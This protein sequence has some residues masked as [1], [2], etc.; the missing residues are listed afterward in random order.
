M[1]RCEDYE[2]NVMALTASLREY[3]RKFTITW[4]Q[5]HN[6]L[7]TC[8]DDMPSWYRPMWHCE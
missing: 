3:Q 5:L 8:R 4:R 7:T 1:E 2:S 6:K